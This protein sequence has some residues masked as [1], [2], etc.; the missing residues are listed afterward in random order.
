M[1]LSESEHF[2]QIWQNKYKYNGFVR[3]H[4]NW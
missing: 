2:F 4:K 3:L 1:A